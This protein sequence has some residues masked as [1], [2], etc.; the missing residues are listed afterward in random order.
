MYLPADSGFA[1]DPAST[2]VVDASSQPV[3]Q[4]DSGDDLATL[5]NIFQRANV[6]AEPAVEPALTLL[7]PVMAN[8]KMKRLRL[9]QSDN[10]CDLDSNGNLGSV[11]VAGYDPVWQALPGYNSYSCSAPPTDRAYAI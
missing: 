11:T 4:S 5:Q 7:K 9:L 1:G 10:T 2:L 6:P 8:L 3:P